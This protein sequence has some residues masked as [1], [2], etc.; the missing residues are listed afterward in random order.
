MKQFH[1]E[2]SEKSVSFSTQYLV[3]KIFTL[4]L[5]ITQDPYL[6]SFQFKILHQILNCN[7]HLFVWKVQFSPTCSF[8]KEVNTIEHHL[9]LCLKSRNL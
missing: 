3:E 8:C 4:P 1:I 5:E 2:K 7:Y 6:Q 9:F